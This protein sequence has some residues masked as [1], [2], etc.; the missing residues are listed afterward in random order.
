MHALA[1]LD[2]PAGEGW[3]DQLGQ[4][5]AAKAPEAGQGRLAVWAATDEMALV[6]E[7]ALRKLGLGRDRA[8]VVSV[9]GIQA[10]FD[11]IRDPEG[12]FAATAALPYELMGEAAMDVIDDLGAG[13][14]ARADRRRPLSLHRLRPGRPHQR[15]G[16]E[17]ARPGRGGPPRAS[18][19]RRLFW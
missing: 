13:T 6:A 4:E 2:R 12:L 5:L 9:G 15:A 19:C 1:K 10:A 14:P 8:M 7:A 16:R 17:R 11:R 3:R 18:G